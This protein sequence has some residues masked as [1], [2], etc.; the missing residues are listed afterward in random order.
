MPVRCHGQTNLDLDMLLYNEMLFPISVQ[1]D[2]CIN[3]RYMNPQLHENM[4]SCDL[5]DIGDIL[6]PWY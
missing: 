4:S 3:R 2:L 6:L 5:N 1:H